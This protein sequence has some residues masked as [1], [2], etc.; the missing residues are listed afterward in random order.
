MIV[1]DL[2]QDLDVATD[3]LVLAFWK[4]AHLVERIQLEKR[5]LGLSVRDPEREL[6]LIARYRSPALRSFI[7]AS[8]DA[9]VDFAFGDGALS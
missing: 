7:K 5:K 4:R 3:E 8:I 6:E 9:C 1:D 2:R